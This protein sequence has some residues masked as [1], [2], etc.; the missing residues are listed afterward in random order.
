MKK[1]L[2]VL[3]GLLSLH[4]FAQA[5]DTTLSSDKNIRN[6]VLSDIQD[7]LDKK[8]KNID[9]TLNKLDHKVDSLDLEIAASRDARDKADKLLQRVQALEAKQQA[10]EQHEVNVYQANYQS[11]IINL[12]SM[13][14]EI[15]PLLLFNASKSFFST[16]TETAN[17]LNYPGY[18]EWYKKFTEYV[19]REK[20]HEGSLAVLS[21]FTQIAGSITGTIPIAGPASSAL[22]LGMNSYIGSMGS[23]KKELRDQ[24]EK[25]MLLTAKLGQFNYDMN[26]VEEQWTIVQKE[27]GKI[28]THYDT[29]LNQNLGLL[30]VPRDE[31]TSRFSRETDAEK[32]YEFLTELRKDASSLVTD[33]KTADAKNWK[34]PIYY[35]LMDVQSLK[36]RFGDLTFSIVGIL[37]NYSKLIDKYRNDPDIGLKVQALETKLNTLKDTFD[38]AFDPN[39]YINSATRM[40]LVN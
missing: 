16:L 34:Q 20:D 23:K 6:K 5:P 29:V 39:D 19:Q 3:S 35:Q 9:Q 38:T 27:L 40:Y 14:K 7:N 25:M 22:F 18:Q 31:Y 24:S 30:Q 10:I 37:G 12:V 26:L 28:Q 36:M 2:L 13:D 17:P 11:A 1:Y 4:T 15:K 32:R 33:R 8:T 21:G